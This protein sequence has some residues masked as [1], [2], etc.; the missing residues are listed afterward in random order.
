MEITLLNQSIRD[1][2]SMGN[3]ISMDEIITICKAVNIHDDIMAMPMKYN[4][5]I[6]NFGNNLSGGQRQR[7]ALARALIKKP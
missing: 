2:I 5:V 7:I 1:N 6:N 4:T 3:N